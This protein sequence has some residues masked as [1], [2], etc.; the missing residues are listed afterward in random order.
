MSAAPHDE[1]GLVEHVLTG[2]VGAFRDLVVRYQRLVAH[3]VFRIAPAADAED[4]CQEVF[5]KV[6][7]RLDTFRHDAK[8]ST[9]IARIARNTALHHLEKRRPDLLGDLGSDSAGDPLDR[10]AGGDLLPDAHADRADA[11]A[12]L[13][14]AIDRL[15]V[16]Y[17]TVLTLFHL[18]EMSYDEI[19]AVTG[20]PL[21]TV[22]NYLHRA[23]R[24]LKDVLLAADPD[25]QADFHS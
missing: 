13:H 14:A 19:V 3:I 10:L 12:R 6:Y 1:T 21:G 4:I 8:L 22:K 20:L 15:P 23:R 17:R 24:L 11:H 5:V 7:R 16:H 2:D 18:D 25:F 9:W